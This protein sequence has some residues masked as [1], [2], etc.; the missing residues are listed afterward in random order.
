MQSEG[1]TGTGRRRSCHKVV[2]SSSLLL[3]LKM[4]IF[5]TVPGNKEKSLW[6]YEIDFMGSHVSF[7]LG[8][9]QIQ[10]FAP[11]DTSG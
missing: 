2:L 5:P 4:A 11:P 3:A 8:V 9:E 7:S 1:T 6:F 10:Y